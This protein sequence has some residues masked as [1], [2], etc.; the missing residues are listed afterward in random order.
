MKSIFVNGMLFLILQLSL[1]SCFDFAPDFGSWG[2]GGGWGPGPD[3]DYNYPPGFYYTAFFGVDSIVQN[4][5]STATIWAY[6]RYDSTLIIQQQILNYWKDPYG[7][8]GIFT[9]SVLVEPDTIN[10]RTLPDSIEL[11]PSNYIRVYKYQMPV[12]NVQVGLRYMFCLN[13][14]FQEKGIEALNSFCI[15]NQ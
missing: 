3:I 7:S 5:D 4:T 2:G 14:K 12:T 13:T 1:S 11:S 6:V 10:F 15:T 8:E 9:D